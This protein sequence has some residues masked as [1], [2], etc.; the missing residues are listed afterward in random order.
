MSND[1]I[2]WVTVGIN[3]LLS[4]H[5][6]LFQALGLKLFWAFAGTIFAWFGIT[7]AL[8]SASGGPPFQFGHFARLLLHTSFGY[9]MITYY[10]TPL[11]GIGM[12]FRHLITEH[13]QALI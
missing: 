2:A 11:P 9:A 3:E 12:G 7:S 1:F 5:A 4:K 8:Q 10:S 6:D 13:A